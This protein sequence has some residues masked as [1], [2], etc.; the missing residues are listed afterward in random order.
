MVLRSALA[1]EEERRAEYSQT[2]TDGANPV[3]ASNLHGAQAVGGDGEGEAGP[4]GMNGVAGE[5]HL[6]DLA[7][8][9]IAIRDTRSGGHGC[10]LSPG[11]RDR[12]RLPGTATA[13]A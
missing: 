2:D 13:G 7:H 6:G 4:G 5:A 10:G 9:T 3:E 12:D 8:A 11:S 1:T